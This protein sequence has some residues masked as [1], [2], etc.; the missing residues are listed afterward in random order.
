MEKETNKDHSTEIQ[1]FKEMQFSL[2]K[3]KLAQELY[4][5]LNQQ[6]KAGISLQTILNTLESQQ[7]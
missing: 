6:K 7:N 2:L 4:L 3:A 1:E 5:T